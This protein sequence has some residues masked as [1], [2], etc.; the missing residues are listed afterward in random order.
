M[1]RGS[2]AQFHPDGLILATGTADSMV[3]VWDIKTQHNVVTFPA[4]QVTPS[5]TA[6][7]LEDRQGVRPR[8]RLCLV[9]DLV[10]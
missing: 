10:V 1:R 4:H 3:R 6:P 5:P 2:D 9:R 8:F 7:L